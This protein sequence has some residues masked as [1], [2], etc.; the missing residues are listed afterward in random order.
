[1]EQILVGGRPH[2][3]ITVNYYP[4]VGGGALNT[5]GQMIS[6]YGVLKELRVV[7][8]QA[9]TGVKTYVATVYL[10]GGATGLA[11]T[12]VGTDTAGSN[13]E[14][15]LKVKPG[16]YVQLRFQTSGTPTLPT[17]IWSSVFESQY[18]KHSLLPCGQ[19][20]GLLATAGTRYAGLAQGS[21]WSSVRAARTSV[22]SASGIIRNLYISLNGS[23]GASNSFTFTV[24][25]NGA[26]QALSV[27]IAGAAQ[28]TGNDC[29]DANVVSVVPGDQ[30]SFACVTVVGGG[31]I[32]AG[33]D[34]KWGCLFI[35]NKDGE[36]LLLGGSENSAT[37]GNA[38][39]WYYVVNSGNATAQQVSDALSK[40]LTRRCRLSDLY[41]CSSAAAGAAKAWTFT[42]Q[43][44]G[45]S[46]LLSAQMANPAVSASDTT[47]MT[48]CYTD[49]T[50]DMMIVNTGAIVAGAYAGWGLKMY[51]QPKKNLYLPEYRIEHMD[52]GLGL[53]RHPR[54]RAY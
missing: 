7:Y 54:S 29:T 43:R 23:P 12:T 46:E 48:E 37:D 6:A 41:V 1:M 40:R 3:T 25:K 13:M 24:W 28:T 38:T 26:A 49:D 20:Y 52:P 8:D 30:I 47:H 45:A 33:I 50:L 4:L 15:R 9:P 5:D 34:A 27:Q 31:A 14:T 22:V 19:T 53:K 51:V 17:A 35:A 36:S 16:D 10:N 32:P 42:L 18:P 11:V 2:A 39:T 44:N 21:T